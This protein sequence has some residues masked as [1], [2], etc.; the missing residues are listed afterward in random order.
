MKN[1]SISLASINTSVLNE[2]TFNFHIIDSGSVIVP[3]LL[4]LPKNEQLLLLTLN[5]INAV[6]FTAFRIKLYKYLL[7]RYRLSQLSP[8]NILI[9][10]TCIMQHIEIMIGV[11]YQNLVASTGFSLEEL[12]V[13]WICPF[14]KGI[15]ATVTIYSV[16]GG[17]GIAIYRILLIKYDLIVKNFIGETRLL[18]IILFCQILIIAIHLGLR[19]DVGIVEQPIRPT[20]MNFPYGHVL[21]ILDTYSVSHGNDSI[22]IYQTPL[23]FFSALAFLLMIIIELI[24]YLIFFCHLFLHD[25]SDGI[26]L[27]LE[28]EVIKRRNTRNGLTFFSHFCSFVAEFLMAVTFMIAIKKAN[29]ENP[30]FLIYCYARWFS[31][32]GIAIIEVITSRRNLID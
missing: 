24:I 29:N 30:I 3:E 20:C 31:L 6:I 4:S 5:W 14:L 13:P 23:Y 15:L 10:V 27:I 1:R 32:S 17:L 18:G 12:G 2:S 16:V 7:K 28:S 8:I 21:D 25:N 26:K 22:L 19:N 9:L 11:I